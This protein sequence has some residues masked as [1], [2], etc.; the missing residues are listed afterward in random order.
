[1]IHILA[2][3]RN[4]RR[5]DVVVPLRVAGVHVLGRRAAGLLDFLCEIT[6][7]CRMAQHV[8]RGGRGS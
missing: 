7:A 4:G 8:G 5:I 3:L 1:M 6:K 2:R